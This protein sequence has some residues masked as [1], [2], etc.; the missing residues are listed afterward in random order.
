MVSFL[1]TAFWLVQNCIFGYRFHFEGK[2]DV[3]ITQV[4]RVNAFKC[5]LR[6]KWMVP[7]ESAWLIEK[8]ELEKS[9]ASTLPM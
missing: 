9:Q 1:D 2:N 5:A 8:S 4:R 7:F 3:W 6:N